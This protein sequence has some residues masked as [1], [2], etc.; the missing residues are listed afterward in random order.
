MYKT[1]ETKTYS[2]FRQTDGISTQ[3]SREGQES[4][5]VE[6][7]FCE[8]LTFSLQSSDTNS[9]DHRQFLLLENTL[10]CP[11]EDEPMANLGSGG[12]SSV[13]H[14]RIK[15]MQNHT[16]FYLVFLTFFSE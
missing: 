2:G 13:L 6:E 5:V 10:S 14:I 11:E 12:G 4:A 7:T 16:D 1:K 8:L 3:F 15:Q 9:I